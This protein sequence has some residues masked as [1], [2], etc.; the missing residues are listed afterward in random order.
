MGVKKLENRPKSGRETVFL[1][2][3]KSKKWPKMAL[4]GT[5]FTGKKKHGRV[6]GVWASEGGSGYGVGWKRVL[7]LV[8]AG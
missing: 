3:K 2:V 7:G 5:F 6:L 4:T 8:C 1:P